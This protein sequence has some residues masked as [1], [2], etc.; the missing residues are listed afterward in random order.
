MAS[1]SLV[2]GS[3]SNPAHTYSKSALLAVLNNNVKNDASMTLAY[4]LIAAKLNVA[5]GSNPASVQTTLARA[6]ELLAPFAGKL[7]TG[8]SR[9]RQRAAKWCR[10]R[11]SSR[12]TT[13]VGSQV[14]AR[15]PT[16]RLSR[17]L[18]GPTPAWSARR[19]RSMAAAHAI[20]MVIR[21]PSPG[22]SGMGIGGRRHAVSHIRGNRPVHG[23]PDRVRWSWWYCHGDDERDDYAAAAAQPQPRRECQRSVHRERGDAIQFSSAGSSD[24]DDD[25]LTFAWDFG[26]GGTSTAA[27]PAH[28]YQAA[29][30]YTARLTVADGRGGSATATA[31]VTVTSEPPANRD[32]VA[33]ANGPYAGTEDQAIQFS[34]SGSTDPDNDPLQ[35]SWDFGDGGKSTGRRIHYTPTPRQDRSRRR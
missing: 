31:A 15:R 20:R 11:R 18:E 33:N 19:W 27:N 4:Q 9:T 2:L 21:S 22:L 24:P 5:I 25:A 34:S 28:T 23:R 8:S 6:D 35:F 7:P 29:G 30:P 1:R 17:M 32:P 13:L 26:D 12:I 3:P 16:R 14:V 10:S